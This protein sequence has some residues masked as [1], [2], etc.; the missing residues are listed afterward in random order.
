MPCY[1]YQEPAHR[2]IAETANKFENPQNVM[3]VKGEAAE[4]ARLSRIY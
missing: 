4:C 1:G 2:K 3:S